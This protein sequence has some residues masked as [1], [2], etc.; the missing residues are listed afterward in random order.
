MLNVFLLCGILTDY[1]T[2]IDNLHC[3]INFME[4]YER[5]NQQNAIVYNA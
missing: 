3:V 5:Y 1:R 2:F 4:W